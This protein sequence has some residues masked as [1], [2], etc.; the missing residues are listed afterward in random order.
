MKTNYARL[1]LVIASIFGIWMLTTAQDATPT[2]SDYVTLQ[3]SDIRGIAPD[4]IEG[5][6]TGAGLGYALP[7]E[8]NGYPGPRHVLDLANDLEL[9]DEQ[10]EQIQA[11]YD[12]MLPQ[13]I[14]FGEALLKQEE[15]I[16]L[17]FR[18]GSVSDEWLRTNLTLAAQLEGNLR[19]VHL[20]THLD[21]LDILT[22]HQVVMYNQLRGYDAPTNTE[23][24][25]GHS[26]HGN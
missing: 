20:S 2:P 16:E 6:R 19:F 9:T 10:L 1:L 23:N 15:T 21:T 5:Y 12:E 25:E 24:H 4:T 8:L 7:A 17:A 13:A 22:Q 11:L 26:G 18:E 14:E 3:F